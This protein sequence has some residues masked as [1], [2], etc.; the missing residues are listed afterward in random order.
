MA[1]GAQRIGFIFIVTLGALPQAL[2]PWGIYTD[3]IY[4]FK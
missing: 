1:P 2:C 4:G 3:W